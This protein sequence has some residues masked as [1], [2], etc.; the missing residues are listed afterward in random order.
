M[1]IWYELTPLDT[2]F[3]RGSEPM[4]AG[5]P[6]SAPIFPPPVSVVQGALRTALL[7]AKGVSFSDYRQGKVSDEILS[8]IGKCGEKAPFSVVA[9]LIK[10]KGTVYA[11]A[12]ANWFIDAPQKP[13][14]GKGY[15]GKKVIVASS[16]EAEAL[17]MGIISS[18][19]PV[20]LVV[21]KHDAVS[22]SGCWV[23]I[24][25]FAQSTVTF[26]ESDVVTD[27]EVYAVENR[28]GIELDGRRTVVEGKLYSANHIRLSDGITIVIAV[29]KNPGLTGY[30][31]L[32]LG[33]EQ[34]KCHYEQLNDT[35]SFSSITEPKG[36]IA[37]AP[38]AAEE[39][40]LP[41]IV[42]AYKPVMTSGW[43]LSRGFHKPTTTWF[44]A[45]S[46]F[47][48]QINSSCIPLAQ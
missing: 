12:P 17:K 14:S 29:D 41:M 45:G 15:V 39:A 28:V 4:E 30:G 31:M 35:P 36:F 25:L 16:T 11:P 42:S 5:Q 23:K 1:I 7:R 27:A 44:P 48:E 38:V 21:A 46:V 9:I 20:R 33:G 13:V 10:F 3:F 19:G 34:R 32:Q 40:Y 47:S 43:D 24:G 18:S 6:T 22:L 2:L 26:A 8:H 37:L